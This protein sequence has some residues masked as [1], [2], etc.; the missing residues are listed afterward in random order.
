MVASQVVKRNIAGMQVIK[1]LLLLLEDNYAMSELVEKLNSV[2]KEPIFNNNVVSKYINTCRYCGIDICKINNKYFLTKLPFGLDLSKRD[3]D[4]LAQ[5][6]KVAQE[7]FSNKNLNI[8]KNFIMNLNKFSNKNII[9]VE[10]KNINLVYEYFQKAVEERRK[11]LLMLKKKVSLECTPIEIVKYNNSEYFKIYYK[12]KIKQ[13][14]INRVSGLELLSKTFSFEDYMQQEVIYKLTG[15]LAQRYALRENEKEL[16]RNLPEYIIISNTGEEKDKLLSR[17][18]RYDKY[19]EILKPLD[20]REE[21]KSIIN[22][23][24]ANYGE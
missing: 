10:A 23:M 17:L 21:M 4:L 14:S 20:Y 22:N 13:I 12:S 5:M 24:L 18:L 19:C 8:F 6:Q 15:G 9:K 7:K 16:S 2:E 3:L 11:V 1:T